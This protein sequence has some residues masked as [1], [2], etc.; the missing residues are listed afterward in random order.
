MSD[1]RSALHIA[2][3]EGWLEVVDYLLRAGAEVNAIDRF[4]GSPLTDAVRER[5][6]RSESMQPEHTQESRSIIATH[7]H[8]RVQDMLRSAGGKLYGIDAG[9]LL[10]E[11]GASGN[12]D[13]LK[14]YCQNGIDINARCLC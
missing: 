8:E 7:D 11:T 14:A 10:C 2:A 3:S 1:S 9:L 6:K 13:Q 5:T 4:G 12:L